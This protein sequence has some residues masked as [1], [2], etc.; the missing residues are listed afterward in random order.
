MPLHLLKSTQWKFARAFF[1]IKS[2]WFG[3]ESSANEQLL[4]RSMTFVPLTA[5]RPGEVCVGNHGCCFRDWSI[6]VAKHLHRQTYWNFKDLEGVRC[7]SR[8]RH[9]ILICFGKPFCLRAGQDFW[10][11]TMRYQ[12]IPWSKK[13]CVRQTDRQTP[14]RSQSYKH[15]PMRVS[16]W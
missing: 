10:E 13:V 5:T 4:V 3:G 16:W 12:R 11:E 1:V 2:S 7:K 8:C 14:L 15:R 6:L 9:F